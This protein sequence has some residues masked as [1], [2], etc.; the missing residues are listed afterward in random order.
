MRRCFLVTDEKHNK[1]LSGVFHQNLM[2]L[3]Y[4]S[5]IDSRS[6]TDT[7]WTYQ[8]V[9]LLIIAINLSLQ[10]SLASKAATGRI[11]LLQQ[12]EDAE[13]KLDSE[14]NQLQTQ[15]DVEKQRLVNQLSD[16]ESLAVECM[17]SSYNFVCYLQCTYS[18]IC[19]WKPG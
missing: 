12:L 18:Q 14:I 9:A 16:G 6:N 17:I 4:Y 2:I 15:R 7:W 19:S 1:W 11:H 8:R 3:L 13:M 5:N 10:A